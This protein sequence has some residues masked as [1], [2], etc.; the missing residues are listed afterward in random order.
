MENTLLNVSNLTVKSKM[1]GITSTILNDV[2]ITVNKGEVVGL[3]GKTGSGK[4]MLG[5][6]V[7]DL[8]PRLCYVSTGSILY[9]KTPITEISNF[10]GRKTTMVFQDPMQS[11]NPLQTIGTQVGILSNNL[12]SDKSDRLQQQVY[13]WFSRVMLN[14]IPDILNRYPHQLSGGQMQRVMIAIS[15]LTE[16][17]FIIAD[18]I[19]TGLDAKTKLETM[20]LLQDIQKEQGVSILLISH[21]SSVINRYCNRVIV[22]DS[23][24]IV[25]TK[26]DGSPVLDHKHAR[27]FRAEDIKDDRNDPRP[28]ADT[29]KEKVL[30][31]KR[32][33]KSYSNSGQ[34][35]KV[36][37]GVSLNLFRGETLGIIGESGSGKSTLAKMVLNILSRDEGEMELITSN[38][39]IK[40]L[41]M[42]NK[43]IGAVLQDSSGSL[44]PRMNIQQILSE[45]LKIL[46]YSEKGEIKSK[47]IRAINEIGLDQSFLDRY[48]HTL[49]GGQRQRVSIARAMML[50]PSVLILDEPTSA[51]D[52]ATKKKILHLLKS[53]QNKQKTSYLFI[54][55]DLHVI[56]EIA[57]EVS[58]LFRGEIIETGTTEKIMSNPKQD[59][60]KKLVDSHRYNSVF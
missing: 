44:N 29:K 24:K 3:V 16:P 39:R 8:L 56:S 35:K 13:K 30:S 51:L 36:L 11:L 14:N 5:W 59:Y 38:E 21:D 25:K 28:S 19:T 23:G 9:D 53:L 15:M 42:P 34:S 60:T 46:G 22:I 4:S 45:P 26:G 54:S 48:P 10:R 18:E 50:E 33:C 27:L 47:T 2:N 55:H 37:K 52:T 49:S 1:K 31:I 20:N 6:A 57:S 32:F 7:I 12:Y 43:N 17:E 40:N 58:V 41:T